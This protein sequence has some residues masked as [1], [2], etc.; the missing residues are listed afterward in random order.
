MIKALLGSENLSTKE[1]AKLAGKSRLQAKDVTDRDMDKINKLRQKAMEDPVV[2]E[3]A[4][5]V[6]ITNIVS[7]GT[8]E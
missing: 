6:H 3:D 5:V 1:A 2:P 7:A 4:A 8:Y